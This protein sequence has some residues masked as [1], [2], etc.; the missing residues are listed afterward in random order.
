MEQ[1]VLVSPAESPRVQLN[2]EARWTVRTSLG[3][4]E[5]W[6]SAFPAV[7]LASVQSLQVLAAQAPLSPFP[8]RSRPIDL[9][10]G[11]WKYSLHSSWSLIHSLEV[12]RW[13][14]GGDGGFRWELKFQWPNAADFIFTSALPNQQILLE[15][16]GQG[17][18]SRRALLILLAVNCKPLS[19]E[20]GDIGTAMSLQQ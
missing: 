19:A 9:G 4:K 17:K 7:P 18:Q 20:G 8:P 5:A 10:L 14:Q 15:E 13:Q 16:A 6:S 3:W 12:L 1:L 2:L 11:S